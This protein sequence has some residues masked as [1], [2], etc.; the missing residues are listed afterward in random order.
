MKLKITYIS[1]SPITMK[2]MYFKL[3]N[4]NSKYP[5]QKP[6]IASSAS[7]ECKNRGQSPHLCI[8]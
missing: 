5:P 1:I 6:Q 8:V 4:S 7:A 3:K 2:N